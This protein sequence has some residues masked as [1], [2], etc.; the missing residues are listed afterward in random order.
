M[1]HH[2]DI[3]MLLLEHGA[4]V[5]ILNAEAHCAKAIARTADIKQLIEGN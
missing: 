1:C 3:V 5:K 2:Q 4:D